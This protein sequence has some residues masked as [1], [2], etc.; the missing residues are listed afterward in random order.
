MGFHQGDQMICT[1][2]AQFS[3][4]SPKMTP[5]PCFSAFGDLQWL[6]QSSRF[7][8]SDQIFTEKLRPRT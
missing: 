7:T 6:Q 3:H 5:W 8:E 1:E 2:S 4:K